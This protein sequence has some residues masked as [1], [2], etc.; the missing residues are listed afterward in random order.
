MIWSHPF[1]TYV[2][3][4][5]KVYILC[6]RYHY[7]IY[8]IES[9]E[10]LKESKTA[11]IQIVRHPTDKQPGVCVNEYLGKILYFTP[12]RNFVLFDAE[13]EAFEQFKIPFFGVAERIYCET[14]SKRCIINR[15][16]QLVIISRTGFDYTAGQAET[17]FEYT[18]L[19]TKQTAIHTTRLPINNFF[20]YDEVENVCIR[21]N[22]RGDYF[23][24]FSSGH[25]LVYNEHFEY[26]FLSVVFGKTTKDGTY[27][28]YDTYRHVVFDEFDNVYIHCRTP[29][30]VI[31]MF[32]P[33]F[34]FVKC[35]SKSM[36]G[37]KTPLSMHYY[38][39]R[40]YVQR[41]GKGEVY[42][43][44]KLFDTLHVNPP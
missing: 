25:V 17:V 27:G 7:K 15:K 1:D 41:E 30:C 12:E 19:K 4:R 8:D 18:C 39:N 36:K 38:N 20:P 37:D 35:I 3:I 9:G 43:S 22:S 42:R 34:E 40:L 2:F 26:L 5:N 6:Y 44:S 13:T 28:I 23:A 14:F 32:S 16:N 21:Q 33:D 24:L 10:V 11:N 31:L 29:D